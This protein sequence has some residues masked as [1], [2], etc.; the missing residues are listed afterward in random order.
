MRLTNVEEE[1]IR[2]DRGSVSYPEELT[3][4]KLQKSPKICEYI[5]S[6]KEEQKS[7]VEGHKSLLSRLDQMDMFRLHRSEIFMNELNT[8]KLYP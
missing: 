4:R 3:T 7:F 6:A 5:L 2:D 8:Q 1:E